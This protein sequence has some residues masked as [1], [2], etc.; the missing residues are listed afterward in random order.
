MVYDCFT[1]R[2]ELDLLE[3]RLKILDPYVDRFIISEANKTHTNLPKPYNFHLNKDR[4]SHWEHKITYLPIK[5]DDTNLDFNQK[6]TTYTP[7]SPAWVFE[8][9]QRNAL[10]HGLK[11]IEP[12]DI[13]MVGDLDEI[14]NIAN[15]PQD[16][17]TPRTFAQK[18]FYY[19]FNNKS[20]GPRDSIWAGT[21]VT[22]GEHF[23]TPQALR[24]NRN[25]NSPILEGGWHLS[26]MG[27]KEMIKQKIQTI[28]HT[29]F[30][31]PE[32]YSD[33]NIGKCLT[34]GKDIFDRPGMNFSLVNLEDEYPVHILNILKQYKD[35]I[36]Y[37]N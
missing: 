6:D 20:V 32:F 17:K 19:Y 13:I 29:E 27:G 36:Y 5:L 30:N 15:L 4:F 26:Y 14:P 18:F 37:E 3:I 28:A 24:N 7:T 21:V 8:N 23:T 9:Q 34:E 2:D 31:R 11:N 33:E 35:F 12:N 10:L 16:L 1:L 22:T 25:H